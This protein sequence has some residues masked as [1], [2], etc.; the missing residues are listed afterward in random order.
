[1]ALNQKEKRA[2][3]GAPT[4]LYVEFLIVTDVTI[5]QDHAKFTGSTNKDTIFNSMKIYFSFLMNAVILF[6]IYFFLFY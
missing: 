1:M 5:Y 4:N 3:N 2:V 6:I